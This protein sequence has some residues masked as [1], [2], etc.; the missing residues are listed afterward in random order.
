MLRRLLLPVGPARLLLLFRSR[1]LVRL[2]ASGLAGRRLADP[3][4]PFKLM[5]RA[6]WDDLEPI[7]AAD[8]LAPSIM[9]AVGAA[10]RGW[11]VVE[12]PVTHLARRSGPGTLRIGRLV[13][14]SLRGLGQLLRFRLALR[15]LPPR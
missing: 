2:V 13:W 15:R 6:V 4:A 11:R 5:R 12:V 8:A 3:N 9:L 10:A 7:V 14:F 1:K